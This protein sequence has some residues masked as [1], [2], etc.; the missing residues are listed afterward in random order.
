M[1]SPRRRSDAL[2]KDFYQKKKKTERSVLTQS[3]IFFWVTSNSVGLREIWWAISVS[4]L[5]QLHEEISGQCM[6]HEIYSEVL[7]IA[8]FEL[9][10]FTP[11]T[12]WEYAHW[13][14]DLHSQWWVQRKHYKPHTLHQH[15]V[16]LQTKLRGLKKH[17]KSIIKTVDFFYFTWRYF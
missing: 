5:S 7:L 15:Q 8:R 1:C 12:T 10:T 17:Y 4:L 3:V 14:L 11:Q 2:P 6:G 13:L 9:G 16:G